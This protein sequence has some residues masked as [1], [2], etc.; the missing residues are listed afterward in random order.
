MIAKRRAS[1]ILLF[2]GCILVL[3]LLLIV[4]AQLVPSS[5]ELRANCP[6]PIGL[7]QHD[8][9]D[10]TNMEYDCLVAEY[11]RALA[12]V[13]VWLVGVT[14][15]LAIATLTA[16]IA[17]KRSADHIPITERAYVF[18]GVGQRGTVKVDGEVVGIWVRITMANYGKTP[19]FVS[20]T[21]IGWCKLDDLPDVPIYRKRVEISDMY[22]PLM[23]MEEVRP[24]PAKVI[25]PPD[26]QYVVF[27]R[28]YY[29]D[30]FGSTRSSGSIYRLYEEGGNIYD[31]PIAAKKLYWESD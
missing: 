27:Q 2:A 7:E 1:Q 10:R 25:M 14:G 31:E 21:C 24:T 8:A 29:Q 3:A 13:T 22:F 23:K 12:R 18:G 15:L 4:V 11:T 30:I 6:K 20:H 19:A 9:G 16:A 28:V 26:G 17:A 5:E